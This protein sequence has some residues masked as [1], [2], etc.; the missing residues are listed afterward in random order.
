VGGV[1]EATLAALREQGAE[2]ARIRI[3]IGPAIGADSYEV[4]PEFPAAF[5]A[6]RAANQEYFRPAP[7]E[8]HFLFDLGRY[9]ADKLAR[10]GVG[11]IARTGGDTAAEAARFFSW[12]RTSL[13]GEKKFGHM[14]SAIALAGDGG[15]A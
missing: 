3:G 2:L 6:E 12:R 1:L 8:K 9:V 11:Q 13:A 5:L 15:D 4:G 14:L 10:L 7:R